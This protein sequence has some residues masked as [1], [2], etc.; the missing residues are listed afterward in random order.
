MISSKLFFLG[1]LIGISIASI[2][3]RW[4]SHTMRFENFVR[5]YSAIQPSESFYPTYSELLNTATSKAAPG[6]TLVLIGGN[7]ILRGA[8]Q[9]RSKIWSNFLQKNLGDSFVVLNYAIDQA[10]ISSFSGAIFW[11]LREIFPKIIFVAIGDQSEIPPIDGERPYSYIFW[12]GYYKNLFNSTPA[13][14]SEIKE[15]RWVELQTASGIGMHV[16]ALLD[17]VTY[18]NDLWNY[19]GYKYF[20]AVWNSA[21]SRNPLIPR[22]EIN[23][24]D[25]DRLAS[26][27][28]RRMGNQLLIDLDLKLLHDR[29]STEK[30]FGSTSASSDGVT[31]HG[32]YMES[33]KNKSLFVF[34]KINPNYLARM[35]SERSAKYTASYLDEAQQMIASGYHVVDFGEGWAPS[36]YYDGFHISEAGGEKMAREIASSIKSIWKY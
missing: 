14:L 3:G 33:Y 25:D 20:F 7:S 26:E 9:R 35:E 17:S 13:E 19:I 16:G 18:F 31:L 24:I 6:K 1:I 28:Q 29:N 36:D 5:F 21:A 11:K 22:S 4:A 27:Q 30:K 12:D 32:N 34:T 23:D 2:A 8:G 10:R 15:Q